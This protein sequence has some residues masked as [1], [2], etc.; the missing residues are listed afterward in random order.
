MPKSGV[1]AQAK[2]LRHQMKDKFKEMS[3]NAAEY[4][5]PQGNPLDI[6]PDDDLNEIFPDR[7]EEAPPTPS[8]E[9]APPLPGDGEAPFA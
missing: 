5:Q 6:N 7:A 3:I 8:F 9:E 4:N 2:E 1:V